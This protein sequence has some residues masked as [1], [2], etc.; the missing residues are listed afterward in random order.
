MFMMLTV[1]ALVLSAVPAL[2]KT[3]VPILCYH[4]VDR[5]GDYFAVSHENFLRQVE[6]LKKH[7]YHFVTLDEYI[8]YT[9]GRLELPEKSVMLTFDDGYESF[10][11]KVY[12]ILQKEN[13]PCMLA[14]VT[15]WTDGEGKPTDVRSVASWAQLREMEQSGLVTVVSHTH[16]LHKQRAIAPQGGAS[17]IAANHMYLDG[18]Y[19]TD[20]EYEKR[21]NDDMAETQQLFEANL[22]H[23]AK[24]MV[25]PY[26]MYSGA[27]I[28]AAQAH[29]MQ[30]TFLLDG[31]INEADPSYM[32]YARRIIMGDDITVKKLETL[33]TKNHD[34][35]DSKPIRMV[36]LDIDQLYKNDAKAFQQNIAWTVKELQDNKISLVALQAFADPDGDGNYSQVYF[37]NTQVPVAADAFNDVCNALQQAGIK[38]VAWLPALT[39]QTFFAKDGSNLV[40]AAPAGKAGWY[41]RLSPFDEPSVAKAA[42]LFRDLGRY[43]LAEGVLFQDDLYLNDFEDVSAPARA[44]YEKAY[45]KDLLKLDRQDKNAMQQ[46]TKLKT[47]Q[48]D[49]VA[50]SCLAAF[51]ENRPQG[52]SMRDIYAEAVTNPESQ[53]WFAQSYPDYLKRYDYTVV[54]AYPYMD[55]EE[56]PKEALADVAK[57]V[58]Q[59]GGNDKT[60]VKVQ[61]YDWSKEKWL[62]GKEVREELNTLKK[63]GTRNRGVYPHTFYKWEK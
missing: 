38:V 55:K 10:Y 9:Q 39:C 27:S 51:R 58:K 7:D 4:E 18:R 22:G 61:T 62:S 30:A 49:K 42:G 46:W 53:E 1:C 13:I 44:A 14:I 28:R 43:T 34:A 16:A 32:T 33:L 37:Y 47:G 60:I 2:A 50:D 24:A 59:A 19:E 31:G 21:L 3:Q 11:T 35:W 63:E 54:M 41:Q 57:A 12:P 36:Q 56:N 8:A 20:G 45:G 40:Q 17:G 29:G 26:G 25:W 6:Y 5:A 48:L 15:S 52:L 23:P